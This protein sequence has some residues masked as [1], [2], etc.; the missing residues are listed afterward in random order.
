[1]Q[2]SSTI[3]R[4]RR[5]ES[6]AVLDIVS[7]Q[8]AAVD[9]LST[10]NVERKVSLTYEYV[11]HW[12]S[13][14]I[15]QI[16]NSFHSDVTVPDKPSRPILKPIEGAK[17]NSLITAVHGIAHAESW[18][19][20]LFWDCIARY[21]NE[22]MPIEFYNEMVDVAEQE[23]K[24]FSLWNSRLIAYDFPYGSLPIHEGL[25]RCAGQTA[26]DLISRLAIVN[27][28][29]EARGLD[30]YPLTLKK[31]INAHDRDS[32]DILNNNFREEIQ[33]VEKGVRWFKYLCKRRKISDIET[34]QDLVRKYNDGPL[35]GPFN[36]AARTEAGFQEEW[37]SPLQ[38][39]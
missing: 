9:V 10:D 26:H 13:K 3:V 31:F 30:T 29:H 33:H 38:V 37:Y 11:H 2:M 20:D 14:V 7:L 34:F 24:H 28:L 8:E 36:I 6:F 32:V 23:A 39:L 15:N 5:T 4:A 17:P 22:N 21:T 12:R 16:T 35:K 19:I 27:L 25:W 18:A 1:M